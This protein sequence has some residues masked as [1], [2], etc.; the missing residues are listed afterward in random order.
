[1]SRVYVYMWEFHVLSAP[2]CVCLFVC[3]YE[4]VSTVV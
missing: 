3:V 4:D 2:I 1:M